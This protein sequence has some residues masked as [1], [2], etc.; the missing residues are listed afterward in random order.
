MTTIDH[1]ANIALSPNKQGGSAMSGTRI[2]QNEI[3]LILE[4]FNSG[5]SVQDLAERL[6]RNWK[7]VA[8]V[9]YKND[10]R[11][12]KL[13]GKGLRKRKT[14]LFTKEQ[15]KEIADIYRATKLGLKKIAEKYNCCPDAIRNALIRENVK[16]NPKGNR[17][18]EFSIDEINKM[19]NMYKTGN[20]QNAIAEEFSTHQSIISK[21]LRQ[22][23]IKPKHRIA[24]G[25]RHGMW[26]GGFINI[27]GYKYIQMSPEHKF[28]SMQQRSGYV[29]EH[30]LIMAEHLE[31]ALKPS[32]TVHHLNGDKLD[33]RIENLELRQGKHGTGQVMYCLDCGSER[34][35]HK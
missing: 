7:T 3:N 24:K 32:E 8:R 21:M 33:N 28:S 27:E 19:I 23:G 34:M 17:Y 11:P 12:Q 20:S 1:Y 9:L 22:N 30:R 15:D 5:R 6:G 4:D 2:S 16:L 10:I 31:R 26:K 25:S 35:G 13:W 29:A 18:R 14:T